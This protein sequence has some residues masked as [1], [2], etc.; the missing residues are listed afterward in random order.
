MENLPAL[1]YAAP[2]LGTVLTVGIYCRATKSPKTAIVIIAAW[3][4]LQACLSLND[5]YLVTDVMPPRFALT[6]LPPVALIIA[7]LSTRAG[8]QYTDGLDMKWLTLL[9]VVRLPVEIMLLALYYHKG[10]PELMT[11]EGRNF[12]ILS[13]ISAPVVYYFGFVRKTLGK[14]T[15]LAWNIICLGLLI[16]IVADAILAAPFPFQQFAFDQPNIAVLYFPFV[17]LP[18]CIVP[19]VLWSHLAA[20]RQLIM[21]PSFHP[22]HSL[23]LK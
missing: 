4:V 15:L 16:H 7:L 19:L 23:D 13:G 9:H 11:F 18:C 21:Q 10:I 6:L 2:I 1:M 3:L 5:F 8:K 17:F 12:D 14:R 22:R 20:I